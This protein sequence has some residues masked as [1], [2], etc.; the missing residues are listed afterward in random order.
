MR[1]YAIAN[2]K[3]GVGK[4]VDT[5]NLSA[6]L[7]ERGR[8]VLALDW[9]PQGHLTEY[10]GATPAEGGASLAHALLGQWSG[11]L[12]EL[13][14]QTPGGLFVIPTSD[15]MFLLEPQMY[16]R[17][18]REYLLS[19]FLDALVGIFD[20]VV[21]DCPPSLGALN[22]NA[23]VATRRRAAG[24]PVQGRIVIPVQAE[25]SSIRAL[26][27]FLRQVATLQEALKIQLDIAGLVVNLY[28]SRKGRIA[29]STLDAFQHH[30]L[31]VLAVF[32][33][34]KEVRESWRKHTTVFDHAPDSETTQGFRAL[35]GRL[36]PELASV[37]AS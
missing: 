14:Q 9:D 31:D 24:E 3:G 8:R 21:I 7:A 10:L 35:V 33:D 18:G 27:L 30:P 29:T 37:A 19:R 32:K 12:S 16:G 5:V 11:E 25:D 26:R 20:D 36:D 15:D 23:L 13:V 1:I 28:D 22:D 17:P 34:L 2:Q 6:A 4:T